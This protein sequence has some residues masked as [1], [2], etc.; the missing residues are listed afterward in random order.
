M[1]E[2]MQYASDYSGTRFLSSEC[3]ECPI[4]LPTSRAFERVA[5]AGPT[6]D[7]KTKRTTLRKSKCP[8]NVLVDSVLICERFHLLLN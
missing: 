2:R 1:L 6:T 8:I 7:Q 5:R 4:D 3:S